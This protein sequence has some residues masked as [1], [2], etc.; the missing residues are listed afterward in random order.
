MHGAGIAART[1]CRGCPRNE[2]RLCCRAFGREE[3]ER[4][5]RELR[6][7]WL[8]HRHADHH[9]GLPPLLALRARLLGADSAPIPVFG[10]W[11]LRRVLSACNKIEPLRYTW[12][13]QYALTDQEEAEAR[14]LEWFWTNSATAHGKAELQRVCEVR[15]LHASAS[16]VQLCVWLWRL[17]CASQLST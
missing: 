16:V 12:I 2:G 8:S 9:V 14:G 5:V 11:P 4:R 7:V 15:H 13:D 10:P 1:L 3:A 17:P 6:C